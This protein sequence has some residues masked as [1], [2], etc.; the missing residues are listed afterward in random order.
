MVYH[1]RKYHQHL[2]E[3]VGISHLDRHLTKLIT[4]MELSDSV[5]DLK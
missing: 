5:E 4:V 2:T 1:R 3:E